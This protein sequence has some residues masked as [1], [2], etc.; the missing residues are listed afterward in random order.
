VTK[1]L[2]ANVAQPGAKSGKD[3]DHKRERREIPVAIFTG[4][5]LID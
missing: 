1:S 2:D 4:L 3:R 5:K